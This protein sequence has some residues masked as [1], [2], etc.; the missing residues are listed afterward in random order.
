MRTGILIVLS[1]SACGDNRE[2]LAPPDAA[3]SIDAALE[4]PAAWGPPRCDRVRGPAAVTFSDDGGATMASQG[5][6]LVG[7]HRTTGVIAL[8]TPNAL[9][10]SHDATALRSEDAGCTWQA[11]GALAGDLILTAAGDTVFGYV[12]NQPTLARIE[13]AV[14]TALPDHVTGVIGLGVDHADAR[15]VRLV[16]AVGLVWDSTDRGS[17][18]KMIGVP[19][20]VNRSLYRA[21]FAAD[22]LDHIIVGAS[23]ANAAVSTDGG[24]TWT[25]STGF[26]SGLFA[27]P[28]NVM[29]VG[30]APSKADVVWAA[31][32]DNT[33]HVKRV[34]R[35]TD[36]GLTF[37]AAV[38]EP[39]ILLPNGK[40]M[41]PH[42][43]DADVLFSTAGAAVGDH[44]TDIFRYDAAAG[45]LTLLHSGFHDIEAVA[46]LPGDP[47]WMWFGRTSTALGLR[48]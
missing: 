8:A 35:S 46:F 48:E 26:S 16:D 14:V 22:D 43:T 28:A 37:T 13:G 30:F 24:A 45:E 27:L 6:S 41:F 47:H 15:H 29:Y 17:T 4:P 40:P 31:G 21:A 12:D 39:D 2:T 7:Q 25:P 33:D 3:P 36:G 9:I 32:V 42:P 10:A 23:S 1:L 5:D 11:I 19:A 18:W 44:G 34:W 38:S 20:F